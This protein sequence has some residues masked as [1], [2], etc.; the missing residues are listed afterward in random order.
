MNAALLSLA[1][2]FSWGVDERGGRQPFQ[3][4]QRARKTADLL[5]R[6][7]VKA[8]AVGIFYRRW[9]PG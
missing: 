1:P 8:K 2:S 9:T 6:S 4:L 5:R 3:R 7:A